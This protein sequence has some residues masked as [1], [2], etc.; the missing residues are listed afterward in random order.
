MS[1][2]WQEPDGGR[3]SVAIPARDFQ[4]TRDELEAFYGCR[5][6]TYSYCLTLDF[7]SYL[8][9]FFKETADA[10]L[11][12]EAFDGESFDIGDKGRGLKWMHWFKGSGAAEDRR[13]CPYRW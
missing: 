10:D 5:L 8:V 4:S 13:R 12:I 9:V 1:E 11:A 6:L 3:F 2:H 7:R